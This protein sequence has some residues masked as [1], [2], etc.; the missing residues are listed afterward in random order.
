MAARDAHVPV[1]TAL[2]TLVSDKVTDVLAF[3]TIAIVALVVNPA[4]FSARAGTWV[5]AGLAAA[6]LAARILQRID[7]RSGRPGAAT[8][9]W[10]W[11]L[12]RLA[13]QCMR[14]YEDTRARM[15]S[16]DVLGAYLL[17]MLA[18]SAQVA[19]YALG[20]LA[21]GVRIP[22]VAAAVAVVA[23]NLGG[24]LRATP[25]NVGVFQVMYVLAVTP[26]GMSRTSGVAAAAL[27][28][29]VQML[30][31]ILAGLIAFSWNGRSVSARTRPASG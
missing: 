31:A 16:V 8:A 6:L 14:F 21:V 17:S 1:R 7:A 26:Y 5:V 3:V 10:R 13:A 18:W 19:T 11:A 30:S 29:C 24:V 25:G 27:I 23:V 15:R 2:E 12:S 9:G 20:A 28:Q 4:L 22:I